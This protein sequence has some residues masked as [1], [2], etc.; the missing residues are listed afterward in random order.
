MKILIVGGG[1][2][3]HALAW[4]VAQSARVS[5][6]YVA[7]GN[8]GTAREAKVEN[9]AID[10]LD[11]AGLSSFVRE[12]GVDLTIVGPEVPLVAGIRDHFDA[13][14]LACFGPSRAAAQLEGSKVVHEIVSGA[15]PDPDGGVSRLY[16]TG[17][18]GERTSANAV[19]RSSSKRMVWRRAK[20]SSSRAPSRKRWT[21]C[22][23]MLSGRRVRRCRAHGR[24]RRLSRRRRGEFHL[25]RRRPSRGAVCELAGSQGARRRRP[26]PEHRRDGRLFA[27]AGRH[28]ADS[29]TRSWREVIRPTIDGHGGRR[30]AVRRISVCGSDDRAGRHAERHRVQL[31]LRRSGSAT[32][33]VASRFGHRRTVR[34][35]ARGSARCRASCVGIR[36]SRL[37]VVMAAGGY[38]GELCEG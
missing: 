14:G 25:H 19:R 15:P 24:H 5:K 23:E 32:D 7:P 6:V 13:Q 17:G 31:P 18:S 26:R 16:G 37:R 29:R 12:A 36:A 35:G 9:V 8:P 4:K 2:R 28:A 34:G 1:G 22:A 10:V 3:E 20:V 21:R 38:P 30:R 33:L 27:G 11:F